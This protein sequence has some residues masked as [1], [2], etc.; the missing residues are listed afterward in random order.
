VARRHRERARRRRARGVQSRLRL[1]HFNGLGVF[2]CH[3]HNAQQLGLRLF[4]DLLVAYAGLL[5]IN[6][7]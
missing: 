5:K 3:G 6:I 2:F 7:R 1:R 4:T